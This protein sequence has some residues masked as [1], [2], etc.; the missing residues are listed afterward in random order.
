MAQFISDNINIDYANIDLFCRVSPDQKEKIVI[1][2][3]KIDKVF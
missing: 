1:E 2:L 3:K